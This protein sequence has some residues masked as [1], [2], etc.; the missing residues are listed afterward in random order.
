MRR[1]FIIVAAGLLMQAPAARAH[2]LWIEPARDTLELRFGEYQ[3]NLRETEQTRLPEF[4]GPQASEQHSKVWHPVAL[5]RESDGFIFP[6]AVNGATA[7]ETGVA[8]ADL[9]KSKI[10]IVKPMFY[11][12]YALAGSSAQP[13]QTLDVVPEG[14]NR[15]RLFYRGVPLPNAPLTLI[16]PDLAEKNL[17]TDASGSVPLPELAKGLT[18]FDAVHLV[19][20]PGEFAGKSYEAIRYRAT[21]SLVR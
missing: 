17:S 20:E 5:R 18:V 16:G 6:A 7:A 13:S 3:E 12:R 9:T 11:A 21:L 2:Y 10:G 15:V 19:K 8:V 14:K 1:F 4:P